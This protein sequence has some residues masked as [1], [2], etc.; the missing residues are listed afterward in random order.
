MFG[1]L[2][3]NTPAAPYG[4]QVYDSSGNVVT[5]TTRNP[6]IATRIYTQAATGGSN[7][8][9]TPTEFSIDLTGI[10]TPAI[11]FHSNG[12]GYYITGS[13]T[14]FIRS[15]TPVITRPSTNTATSTWTPTSTEQVFGGGAPN[16]FY[17]WSGIMTSLVID[18]A[19]YL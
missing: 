17:L 5:D 18:M 4:L 2:T 1:Y 16:G 10:T 15:V 14:R 3:S 9:A 12:Q 7:T 8:G 13:G 19:K 6:L 11:N